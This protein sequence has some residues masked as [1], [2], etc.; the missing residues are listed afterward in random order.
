MEL[1]DFV[2]RN[3]CGGLCCIFTPYCEANNPMAAKVGLRYA[4]DEPKTW[5]APF[6]ANALYPAAMTFPLPIGNYRPWDRQITRETV[7]ALLQSYDEDAA[8]GYFIECD[9]WVPDELHDALPFAPVSKR[10]VAA[11]ELSEGQRQAFELYGCKLGDEKLVPYLGLQTQ[12][13]RYIPLLKYWVQR[14]GV[15]FKN[16]RRVLACDQKPFMREHVLENTRIRASFPKHDPRNALAKR[17]NNAMYGMCLENNAD[18]RSTTIHTDVDAF[19]RAADRPST[20]NFHIFDPE[21]PGFLGLVNSCKG[22]GVTVNTPRMVGFAVLDLSKLIMYRHF[23]DGILRVW[24]TAQLLM[25]DTDSFYVKLETEDLMADISRVNAGEFGAFRI[26]MSK[27]DPAC[28]NKDRLGILKLEYDDAVA[29]AGIRSKCYA[30][31]RA[32][33]VPDK[34]FKG[35]KQGVVKRGI[36]FSDYRSVVLDPSTGLGETGVQNVEQR[37]IVSRDHHLFQLQER[38]KSL[39]PCNDKVFIY[40]HPTRSRPLGHWRNR[41]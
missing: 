25:M 41:Q 26:D 7:M 31:L 15:R 16:V 6:D 22:M 8:V 28:P 32:Q 5:I 34:K 37:R 39:A 19:V 23:Y 40:D 17:E 10:C 27:T 13:G 1:L 3:I 38:K 2:N 30:V 9:L 12:V 35:V 14:L 33:N 4:G 21:D 29:L 36:P 20:A 24:P 11:E 18:H